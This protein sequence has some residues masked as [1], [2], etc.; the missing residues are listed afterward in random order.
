MSENVGGFG[1]R[2]ARNK[3][4]RRLVER[5][6]RERWPIPPEVRTAVIG[7]LLETAQNSNAA[8]RDRTAA[9]RAMLAASR[10]NLQEIMVNIKAQ[11][12]EE[13]R[14]QLEVLERRSKERASG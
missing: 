11:K 1:G 5:A 4:G 3:R 2:N 10:V 9:S 14:R 7:Q 6:F 13:M 12:H 8:P